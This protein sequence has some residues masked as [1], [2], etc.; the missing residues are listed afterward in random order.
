LHFL[1]SVTS[2]LCAAMFS[3]SYVKLRLLYVMLRFVAVPKI[4]GFLG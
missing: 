1:R 3:N 4:V 2:T